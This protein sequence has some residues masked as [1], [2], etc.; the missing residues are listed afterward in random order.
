MRHQKTNIPKIENLFN[1]W[2]DYQ[3]ESN[4]PEQSE[5]ESFDIDKYLI[6]GEKIISLKR[7][8]QKRNAIYEHEKVFSKL[9]VPTYFSMVE[10][11]RKQWMKVLA[12]D[13]IEKMNSIDASNLFKS[14][15]VRHATSDEYFISDVIRK[16]SKA[17][18][19]HSYH[20]KVS[21]YDG[22]E[23]VLLGTDKGCKKSCKNT[24]WHQRRTDIDI[25]VTV[26]VA[27]LLAMIEAHN[28]IVKEL[29]SGEYDMSVFETDMS[30]YF[31]EAGDENYSCYD[32]FPVFSNCNVAREVMGND[33]VNLKYANLHRYVL[34]KEGRLLN[35]PIK[36]T[37][38]RHMD[39]AFMRFESYEY[40]S[41]CNELIKQI[42]E[43]CKIDRRKQHYE[44]IQSKDYAL[45]FMTK[46]N[47]PE[48]VVRAMQNSM[49]ND[50]FGF[51]EFDELTDLQTIKELEKEFKAFQLFLF[52]KNGNITENISLR[53]RRL[54]NH[55]ASGLYYPS[56]GCICIDI[57]H[58]GSFVHEYGHML[59][60][61]NGEVSDSKEFKMI[62]HK[63][64]ELLKDTLEK[65]KI[66]LKGKY[67][68]DYYLTPT[69]VFARTFEIFMKRI[70]KMNN[71]LLDD[72][73]GFAYPSDEKFEQLVS[74][75]F[76]DFFVSKFSIDFS[77]KGEILK[78][79]ST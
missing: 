72:C 55:K 13:D 45:S 57:K 33:A 6:K 70:L 10:W 47:I 42:V 9:K 65:R 21:Y 37:H 1:F 41:V 48:K 38:T 60:F 50:W 56:V 26:D 32:E 63:Y 39:I 78:C 15:E 73:E 14:F 23:A 5:E 54:G 76:T 7:E 64:E 29:E 59:D 18:Y 34:F 43:R 67:D 12:S 53:F 31:V 51:I 8:V 17:N 66:D 44:K 28:Y 75:F 68:L 35:P 52:G 24:R 49:F 71:S 36:H 74:D 19:N 58:A 16:S 4:Q 62:L 30:H 61:T 77:G 40:V 3:I 69:E 25:G 27:E 11:L 22:A 46:K 20:I 2:S 79:A